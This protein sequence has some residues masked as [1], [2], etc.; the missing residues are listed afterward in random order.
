MMNG[1]Y[2]RIPRINPPHLQGRRRR[3]EDA[4]ASYAKKPGR[5]LTSRLILALL[6]GVPLVILFFLG[7]RYWIQ[8]KRAGD[9]PP[10]TNER[11]KTAPPMVWQGLQPEQIVDK[12]L[13]ASTPQERLRWVRQSA[14][15]ADL[16]ERFYREGPGASEKVAGLQKMPAGATDDQAFERFTVTMTDGSRRLLCVPFDE[17]GAG[18]DFKS[19][20]RHCSDPWS[21]V[22]DGTA[23]KA[24]EMRVFL[25]RGSYYNYAFADEHKWLCLI[26]TSPELEH[27]IHLYARRNNTDLL[28][29]LQNLPKQAQRYT[30]ALEN[31]GKGHLKQQWQLTRVLAT[32]WVADCADDQ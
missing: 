1:K 22:L 13:A 32:G 5:E 28:L 23:S 19:Y 11:L 29:F 10:M 14:A 21:A 24:T 27:P 9:P 26:A 12:F 18:V 3:R 17:G 31:S 16:M 8:Q 15:V 2:K 20:A 4:E 7:A 6:I 25:R 30:I